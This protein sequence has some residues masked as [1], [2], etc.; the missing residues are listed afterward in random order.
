M[1]A[2]HVRIGSIVLSTGAFSH[3]LPVQAQE[4]QR[5]LGMAPG[6]GEEHLVG[7]AGVERRMQL[8][9]L[10]KNTSSVTYIA[11]GIVERSLARS[12]CPRRS[13][14]PL[15]QAVLHG[16]GQLGESPAAPAV[17]SVRCPS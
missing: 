9:R 3:V 2:Q 4:H 17:S 11:V 7:L 8:D 16:L 12:Q 5:L 15:R 1:L 6:D 10:A 13:E 14:T